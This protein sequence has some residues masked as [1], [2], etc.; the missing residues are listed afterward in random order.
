MWHKVMCE[1]LPGQPH[2]SVTPD[3]GKEF[4]K[5]ARKGLKRVMF[6]FP[7]PHHPRERGANENSNGLLREFFPKGN[8]LTDTPEDYI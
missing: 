5:Y 3:R 4:S 6:Y 7:A 8:N 1:A 2:L